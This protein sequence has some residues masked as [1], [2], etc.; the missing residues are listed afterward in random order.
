VEVI[1]C[2]NLP[3]QVDEMEAHGRVRYLQRTLVEE[4]LVPKVMQLTH[5]DRITQA[6]YHPSATTVV[7]GNHNTPNDTMGGGSS[8]AMAV[9]LSQ[10]PFERQ[11]E[12]MQLMKEH[13]TKIGHMVEA[14]QQEQ[15]DLQLLLDRCNVVVV[16]R[17]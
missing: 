15:R 14:I 8:G 9:V 4:Q 13:R 10:V 12:W 16:V 1:R 5:T 7:H 2:F 3:L 11:Q 17:S 6:S